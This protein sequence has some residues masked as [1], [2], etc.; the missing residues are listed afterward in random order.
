MP[1][2]DIK[3]VGYSRKQAIA[4]FGVNVKKA[5]NIGAALEEEIIF[6]MDEKWMLSVIKFTDATGKV[7]V[8]YRSA[9]VRESS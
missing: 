9:P 4:Y 5:P 8:T 3:W 7:R 6:R 1:L 2:S